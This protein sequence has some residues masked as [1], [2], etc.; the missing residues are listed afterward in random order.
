MWLRTSSLSGFAEME[1]PCMVTNMLEYSKAL[2]LGFSIARHTGELDEGF[3]HS[4]YLP[5]GTWSIYPIAY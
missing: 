1:A 3:L 2:E 5:P 4:T